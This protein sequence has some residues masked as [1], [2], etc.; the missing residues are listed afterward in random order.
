MVALC[1]LAML[2]MVSD[3]VCAQGTSM[4]DGM[5]LLEGRKRHDAASVA[6]MTQHSLAHAAP[7][8]RLPCLTPRSRRIPGGQRR[9]WNDPNALIKKHRHHLPLLFAIQ[10]VVEVLH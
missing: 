10:G 1:F 2:S 3:T 4:I 6:S 8:S 5:S 9:P 7:S